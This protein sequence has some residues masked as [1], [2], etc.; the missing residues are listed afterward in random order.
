MESVAPSIRSTFVTV[1]A[2]IFIVCSGGFV[3]ISIAQATM[4]YFLFRS[5]QF[6]N[7][8]RESS[9]HDNVPLPFQY[10]FAHPFAFFALFWLL[11]L[12]TFIA[13]VG[14]LRR[15]N[16]A[17]IIFIGLMLFAIVWNLG[18][19][20]LQQAILPSFS[21]LSPHAS[22]EFSQSVQSMTLILRIYS[23][24]FAVGF[25]MLFAYIAKRLAAAPIRAEFNAP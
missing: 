12:I 24:V 1:T 23:L 22:P 7:A 6:S 11:G 4:F 21:N 13:S 15:K 20:W 9:Q 10:F 8:L 5:E 18:G 25:S 16:W 19:I 17:R 3:L 14:L 2:W